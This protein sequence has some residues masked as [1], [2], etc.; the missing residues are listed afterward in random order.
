MKAHILLFITILLTPVVS[1]QVAGPLAGKPT[2]NSTWVGS[3]LG[4]INGTNSILSLSLNGTLLNGEIN[5]DGYIYLLEG[6]VDGNQS[7]GKVTDKITGGVLDY[8]AHLQA[9]QLD[10]K[11]IFRD[12]FGQSVEIPVQFRR[13][14]AGAGSQM[15]AGQNSTMQ[16]STRQNTA[17]YNSFGNS[18]GNTA[19]GTTSG[20]Q[21]DPY[22]VGG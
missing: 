22:L 20:I 9:D 2:N 10:M 16:N 15:S 11:L 3:F 5:A 12:Q 8:M 4:D 7:T 19:S 18:S 13:E 21:R 6:T 1:A 14:A 17:G